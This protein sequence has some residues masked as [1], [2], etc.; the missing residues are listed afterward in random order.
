MLAH[1]LTDK[2]GLQGYSAW[3]LRLVDYLDGHNPPD[4]RD[5]ELRDRGAE[6]QWR[7]NVV[8]RERGLRL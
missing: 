6:L 8:R 2:R 7:A 5:Q 3:L 1:K 4:P